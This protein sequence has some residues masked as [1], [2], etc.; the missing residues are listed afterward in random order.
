[1]SHKTVFRVAPVRA[2][3]LAGLTHHQNR[4]HSVTDT[5]VIPEY[6]HLNQVLIGSGDAKHDVLEFASHYKQAKSDDDPLV[7]AEFVATAAKEYFDKDFTGWREHPEVLKK[8][9]DANMDY[10]ETNKEKIGVA[11]SCILHMDEGAP[12]LHIVTVPLSETRV[13]NKYVDRTET[14]ISYS[15]LLYDNDATL[16]HAKATGTVDTA[17]KLGRLQTE[18]ADHMRE[19]GLDL[20]RGVSNTGREHISPQD[21]R[22]AIAREPVQAPPLPN[23]KKLK[24]EKLK[25]G[26]DVA[27]NGD[28]SQ[29]VTKYKEAGNTFRQA[30]IDNATTIKKQ[31]ET[32]Q[33]LKSEVSLLRNENESQKMQ[34]QTLSNTQQK[35]AEELKANKSLMKEYRE[36]STWDITKQKAGSWEEVQEFEKQSGRSKFNAVDFMKYKHGCDFTTAVYKLSEFFPPEHIAENIAKGIYEN[37]VKEAIKKADENKTKVINAIEKINDLD[38]TITENQKTPATKAKEQ[39]IDK[40]LDA[41]DAGRYRITLM[42]NDQN[43]PSFNLG[44]GKGE[45]GEER[46]Y[47]KDEIKELIPTLSYRNSKGYNIFVTPMPDEQSRFILLDD[48]RDMEKARAL[49]PCLVMQTSPNSKQALY[50][51]SGDTEEA[52]TRQ[53]FNGINRQFGDEKI[54]GLVH[55]IRLAGFTNRKPKHRDPKTGQ[56]PFVTIIES[57]NVQSEKAQTA[58]EYIANEMENAPMPRPLKK[59]AQFKKEKAPD[60]QIRTQDI[61]IPNM[62][63]WYK[64]Q[65]D[66]WQD[67]AD[68][69]KIDRRLAVYLSES[70]FSEKQA[71]ATI[72]ACS[73]D[74][75]SRHGHELNKYLTGKTKG[76]DFVPDA[77]EEHQQ[78]ELDKIHEDTNYAVNAAHEQENDL[79]MEM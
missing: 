55:P 77:P 72:L 63:K 58:I 37:G 10:I 70:G 38:S 6:T 35:L 74:V 23:V 43:M 20:E 42:S 68:L 7:A 36:I 13:K 9:I 66:Y 64:Q 29:L 34:I 12:H 62:S 57:S 79:E 44:K 24:I 4:T 22:N 40:Q 39:I 47:T 59:L 60:I 65:I 3:G 28:N 11:V 30:A 15:K 8:W 31:D 50:K 75:E 2:S 17:T 76:L 5:N 73:P 14:K 49:E 16:K 67:K 32:I 18:Y 53:F 71:Q 61:D 78:D 1:M 51:V 26:F 52:A 56:Y 48:I 45:N 21:Y 41:I 33:S 54:S 25:D 27:K 19:H 46:F 69:S